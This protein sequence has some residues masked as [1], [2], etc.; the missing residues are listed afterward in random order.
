MFAHDERDGAGHLA[1]AAGLK[2]EAPATGGGEAVV[3]GLAVV[4]ARAPV[5][6]EPAAV[7]QAMERGI[8]RALLDLEDLFRG[9]LDDLGDGVAVSLERGSLRPMR[10]CSSTQSSTGDLP[11][12][13]THSARVVVAAPVGHCPLSDGRLHSEFYGRA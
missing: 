5:G 11:S 13:R 1:P 10:S 8:Q 2:R 4:L 7:L 9:A 12:R 6:R 3:L